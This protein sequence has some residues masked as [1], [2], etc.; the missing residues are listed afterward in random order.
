VFVSPVFDDGDLAEYYAG[1]FSAFVGATPDYD[2]GK[3]L[4]FLEIVAPEGG[5]FVEVGANQPTEFHRGLRS[6]YGK[7]VTVEINNSVSSDFWSLNALPDGCADVVAH[8]F[9]LEHIPRVPKFLNEC[10]RVLREGGVMVCEVPDISVYPTE[11]SALQLHEHANHFSQDVL[12]GIAEQF[13]FIEISTNTELCS[14]SFGFVS[15]F[16]KA[17]LSRRRPHFALGYDTG[18]RL[19]M[20][21]VAALERLMADMASANERLEEYKNRNASV[22][23]WAAND[24][25]ARFFDLYP[26]SGN[27]TVVDSNPDKSDYFDTPRVLSPAT[28]VDKIQ[29]AEAIFIFTKLHAEKILEQI[30]LS[31]G[32]KFEFDRVHI[33]DPFASVSKRVAE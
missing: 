8:Y 27:V 33:V 17:S 22:I 28:A 19:F 10:G 13:G 12:R 30:A 4:A 2:I 21:G 20:E 7:V 26:F 25:M 9:V 23:F 15:A 6:L 16:R 31:I 14:R 1:S 29:G 5:L 3:R 18:R 32:K 11:P 24:L